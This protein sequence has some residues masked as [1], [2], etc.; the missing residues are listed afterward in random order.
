MPFAVPNELWGCEF[1]V[2][3]NDPL[4]SSLLPFSTLH[5]LVLFLPCSLY[6]CPGYTLIFFLA[7]HDPFSFGSA[8][9]PQEVDG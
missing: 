3:R 5:F 1:P 8:P 6:L 9:A 7:S 2:Q 4:S